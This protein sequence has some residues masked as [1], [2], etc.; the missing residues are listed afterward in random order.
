M[1]LKRLKKNRSL[2]V[3]D[4]LI[5]YEDL[6]NICLDCNEEFDS[7]NNPDVLNDIVYPKYRKLT[8]MMSPEIFKYLKS[9][10]ML[11]NLDIAKEIN[12]PVEALDL[13]ENGCLQEGNLDKKLQH[14]LGDNNGNV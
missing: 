2:K 3:R 4:D 5:E 6:F 13:F 1:I 9:K 7:I 8:K 14:L 10:K 12:E 11:S